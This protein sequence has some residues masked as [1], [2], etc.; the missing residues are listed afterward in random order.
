MK[1]NR[2]LS[3]IMI[4]VMALSFLTGCA[5]GAQ[6]SNLVLASGGTTGTYYAFSGAVATIL[7][8]KVQGLNLNVQSTGASAANIRLI[9]KDEADIAMV[10]NDVMSYA[11]QGT[12]LFEGEKINS[13]STMA[14]VYAEVCQIVADPAS[15]VTSVADL[16]GKRVSVGDAGSGVEANAKQILEAYGI[17]FSDI[18]MQNL[19]FSDSANA[20]KDKKIDAFFCTA[21]APTTAIMEL[22]TTNSITVVPVDGAEADALMSKYPYYTK[23]TLSADT[24]AG[25]TGAVD[26]LAVKATFIVSNK[27][28][29]ELVYNMT[30]ALFE[31]KDAITA[32]N[33]KG[34]ELDVNA[35]AK[36]EL[37]PF[38]P[39]AEKYYKEVGALQ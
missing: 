6:Q 17:S 34:A 29:E 38:H 8:E 14:T 28:S 13:F 5:D 10:Q 23:Y 33:A 15:G 3:I 20:L 16:K 11:Y 9:D 24:Y 35:A 22:A 21:G 31:S 27:L 36:K 37:V 7:G 25:M 4:A 32:A 1:K 19:S 2:V 18:T 39:G 12:E 26:T 30:K